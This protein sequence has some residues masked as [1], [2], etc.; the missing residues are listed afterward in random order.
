MISKD[1][2]RLGSVKA[3]EDLNYRCGIS[4]L[5]YYIFYCY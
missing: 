5:L 3:E 4:L 1:E 2:N